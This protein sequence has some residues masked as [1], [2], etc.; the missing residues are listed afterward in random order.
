MLDDREPRSSAS[1]LERAYAV[2]ASRRPDLEG[3]L[4]IVIERGDGA[5]VWDVDGNRYLDLI[6]GRGTLPLGH[7]FPAVDAAAVA[8]ILDRGTTL[9]TTVSEPQVRLAERLVERFPCAERALF[10]RTGSCATTASVRLARVATGRN[11]V[12]TSGYH[13]WHDWHL[14][15]FPAFSRGGDRTHF[16]FGYNL[17]LLEELLERHRGDIACVIV[18]PEPNFY[19]DAYFQELESVVRREDVLLFFDEIVSGFRFARGGFQDYVGV[20]PDA[21]TISK[22]MANGYALSAVV[23]RADLLEARDATHV[24]G[25]YNRE[26]TPIAAAHATLDTY[27]ADDVLSH[28]WK[29]GELLLDGLN[30]LFREFGVAARAVRCP[31]DF[32]VLFESD[33][34]ASAFYEDCLRRGVLMHPLGE[35]IRLTYAH[36]RAEIETVL[37]VAREALGATRSRL[38]SGFE[39]DGGHVSEEALERATLALFGGVPDYRAP[40]GR[41]VQAA[42]GVVR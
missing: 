18:T 26:L 32:R 31:P 35:A 6:A 4:P 17:N 38:A 41:M 11:V 37:E 7:R 19:D 39:A 30:V 20:V 10:F 33:E 23:G 42:T 21:A 16:D 24:D 9:C 28:L 1:L 27:D 15:I 2:C 36:D 25:T 14:H 29:V 12:L 8:S 13:G 40:A 22:G 34:V 5:Y 3:C